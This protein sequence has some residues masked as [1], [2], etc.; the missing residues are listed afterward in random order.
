M[1]VEHKNSE[2][3]LLSAK[4]Y[5]TFD[6]LYPL[7]E[8]LYDNGHG[9]IE[10]RLKNMRTARPDE[11]RG[12]KRKTEVQKNERTWETVTEDELEKVE[13]TQDLKEK[14]RRENIILSITNGTSIG[15]CS[16]LTSA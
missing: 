1:Y 6:V 12:Q 7:Q 3:V 16:M 9:F 4:T 13:L 11:R 10:Y 2:C 15:C 8:H 14:V 5:L